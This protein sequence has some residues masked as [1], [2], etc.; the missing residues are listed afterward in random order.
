MEEKENINMEEN[1]INDNIEEKEQ[2]KIE[3]V[4]GNGDLTISPVYEHLEVEKPRPKENRTIV[5]PEVK[6][7]IT[8]KEDTSSEQSDEENQDIDED[9]T[10]NN[11]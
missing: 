2:K 4:T 8:R 7:E 5:V 9:V 10:N 6:D 11:N 3:I 1:L